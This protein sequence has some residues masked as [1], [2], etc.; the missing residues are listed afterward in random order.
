M[1]G[2]EIMRLP[3]LERRDDVGLRDLARA[4]ANDA[5]RVVGRGAD[6]RHTLQPATQFKNTARDVSPRILASGLG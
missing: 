3:H 5:Q 1:M 6:D 4:L 2:I